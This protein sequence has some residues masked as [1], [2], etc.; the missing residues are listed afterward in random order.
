[1]A[2]PERSVAII[3]GVSECP[4]APKLGRLPQ[5]Q[6]SAS[7]FK[8]Y[9]TKT[10]GIHQEDVLDLFDNPAAP[11]DQLEKIEDWIT[12][13]INSGKGPKGP[14]SNLFVFYSG[15]G[16]FTRSDQSYFLA[17]RRTRAGSEGATSIRY[18]DFSSSLKRYAAS[19][20]RYLILDCCFAAAS[21]LPHQSE[22]T[23]LVNLRIEESI[24]GS[25]TAVLC[26]SASSRVSIAP[27]GARFTMFSE[28]L[29]ECLK[30]G[31]TT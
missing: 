2:A 21:V 14:V 9:T 4:A 30:A 11:S 20:R 23:D 5:C 15:H 28:A 6:N 3:L 22:V 26:S 13:R 7:E 18:V 16:G 27:R 24:P 8:K 17:T 25:G 19:V 10:L 31:S 1:M 12:D 29:F